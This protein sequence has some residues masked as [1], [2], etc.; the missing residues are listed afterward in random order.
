VYIVTGIDKKIKMYEWRTV[1]RPRSVGS[2]EMRSWTAP[3][4][5]L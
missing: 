2:S 4:Q 1:Q 3:P 5:T